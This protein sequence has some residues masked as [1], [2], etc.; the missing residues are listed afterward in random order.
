MLHN[1]ELTQKYSQLSSAQY[2]LPKVD[3]VILEIGYRGYGVCFV[4]WGV[5]QK[6]LHL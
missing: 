4:N 1:N 5:G 6:H 3:R 2:N